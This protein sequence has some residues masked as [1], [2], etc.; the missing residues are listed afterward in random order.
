MVH[1]NMIVLLVNIT[2]TLNDKINTP[3]DWEEYIFFLVFLTAG[4]LVQGTSKAW[5]GTFGELAKANHTHTTSQIS[6]LTTGVTIVTGTFAQVGVNST[7]NITVPSGAKA[8]VVVSSGRG[9]VVVLNNNTVYTG[10]SSLSAK[11]SGTTLSL[12]AGEYMI[13][14]GCY[15]VFI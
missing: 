14:S 9:T 4:L 3:P 11:L 8:A 15:I 7:R 12:I 6:G 13:N 5:L 10:Y 1:I 2:I